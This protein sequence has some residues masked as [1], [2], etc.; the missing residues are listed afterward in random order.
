[1]VPYRY[2]QTNPIQSIQFDEHNHFASILLVSLMICEEWPLLSGSCSEFSQNV[3]AAG[4]VNV[5]G[6]AKEKNYGG[7]REP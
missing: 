7:S 6:G 3:S 5:H 1:M 2:I 4:Y